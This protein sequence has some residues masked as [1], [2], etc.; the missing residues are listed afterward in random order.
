M[1]RRLGVRGKILATLAV[2]IFVLALTAGWITWQSL[3]ENRSAEQTAALMESLE[4]QDAAGSAVAAERATNIAADMGIP[5]AK[6]ALVKAQEETDRA[7][8]ARYTRDGVHPT[9]DGF[10]AMEAILRPYLK[11]YLR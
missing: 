3:Q 9:S 2:P 4:L 6:K 8:D 5:G 1:L 10:D 7:L 11:R